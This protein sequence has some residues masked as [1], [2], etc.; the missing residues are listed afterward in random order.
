M[1]VQV[2]Q[3]GRAFTAEN[4]YQFTVWTLATPDPLERVLEAGYFMC[5]RSRLRLGDLLLCATSQPPP[6]VVAPREPKSQRRSMLMVTRLE[7]RA[8]EV[9]LVQDWGTPAQAPAVER[10][11]AP[12]RRRRQGLASFARIGQTRLPARGIRRVRCQP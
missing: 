4:D 7:P 3:L 5:C 11:P 6:R 9:R 1:P 8:V 12:E 2:E 10:A